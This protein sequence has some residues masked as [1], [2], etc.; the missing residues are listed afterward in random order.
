MSAA[1]V[2]AQPL[3][4]TKD[5]SKVYRVGE[6]RVVAL[7]RVNLEIP[8]GRF[9]AVVGTSGSGKST[10]LNMIG[11]LEK[12]TAGQIWV[13]GQ[14]LHNFSE[15]KLVTYRREQVGF[16]FQSF[17]L[18]STLTALQNVALPLSFRGIP[19]TRRNTIAKRMLVALGLGDHLHHR[20][21]QLS[22]GQQQRVGI[23]RAMAVNPKLVFADEPTGNLDSK[24]AEQTLLLFRRVIRRFNQTWLMVTHDPHLAS[25]ADTIVAITDGRI[26]NITHSAHEDTQELS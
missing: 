18:M 15:T 3:V 24:T 20:P 11:G 23:A 12:P 22:G 25:Y 10:L 2:P 8:R 26:A 5:L 19:K 6:S 9:V 4:I 16:I 14:P 7:N 21:T 1:D 17:N 13:D